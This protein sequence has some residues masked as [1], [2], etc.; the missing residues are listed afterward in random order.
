M[1]VYASI[2]GGYPVAE[3]VEAG[4][5]PDGSG[6][7]SFTMLAMPV[8]AAKSPLRVAIPALAVAFAER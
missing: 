6:R 2:V 7:M 5:L 3:R 4:R 1:A 8:A